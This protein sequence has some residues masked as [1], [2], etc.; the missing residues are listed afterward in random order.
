MKHPDP[1]TPSTANILSRRTFLHRAALTGAAAL[2][3]HPL[4]RATPSKEAASAT[5]SSSPKGEQRLSLD[6]LRRWEELGFGL[7]FHYGMGTFDGEEVGYNHSSGTK[8]SSTY[9]PTNLGVDQWLDLA[10]AAGAR[11]AVLTAKH[12]AGHALWPTRHSNFHVGTS[13]DR[14]D[15]VGAFTTGCRKRGI[16]PGLYYCAWDNHHRFGSVTRSDLQAISKEAST[17]L[18]SPRDQRP[19]TTE[20][21]REFMWNQM[22]ELVS[23][24]GPLVEIWIDIPMVLPRDYRDRLYAHL[25]AKQPGAL[26]M[27]NAGIGDGTA[28]NVN[29][30]WPT[31]LVAIERFL[32]NSHTGHVKWRRIEGRE[33][34]VPGEVCDPI[35]KD[36]FYVDS[37]QPRSDGELLGMYLVARNR[38]CNF[39]LNV[40]PDR[41]GRIPARFSE[42]LLRLRKNIDLLKV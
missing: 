7:F 6:A 29:D 22:D 32:P 8:P 31:D 27:F 20:R 10:Q 16:L 21:F 19:Y 11:Y 30:A 41:T 23:D 15:V 39:L 1:A 24:Y 37:D 4:A 9:A 3:A 17:D 13:A 33:Y 36:W 42:A 38:G 5:A 14:T 12:V 18:W 35:G 2:A 25:A 40:P 28:L 26:I 34:Y